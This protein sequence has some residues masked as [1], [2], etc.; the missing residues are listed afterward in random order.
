MSNKGANCD[1]KHSIPAGK[2]DFDVK[3]EGQSTQQSKYYNR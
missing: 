1:L 2:W 3:I